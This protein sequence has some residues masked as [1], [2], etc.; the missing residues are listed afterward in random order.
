MITIN[1]RIV[2]LDISQDSLDAAYFEND[3][4][5]HRVFSNNRGGFRDLLK[6]CRKRGVELRFCMEATATYSW[7]VAEYLYERGFHVYVENPRLISSFGD[8]ENERNSTDKQSAG[9]IARYASSKLEKL[10]LWQ[11]LPAHLKKLRELTRLRQSLMDTKIEWTNRLKSK[12]LG[13][14]ASYAQKIIA[15]TSLAIKTI[16]RD[17]AKHVKETP[18]LKNDV[19]LLR[20]IKGI[21]LLTAVNILAEVPW[22][23]YFE[24]KRDLVAFAGMNPAIRKSGTSIN[25]KATLS[26]KGSSRIR[27][28]L[29]MPAVTALR[30]NKRIV[31]FAS[32][33]RAKGKH[34]MEIV[35]AA[36]RKLLCF[37]FGVL[38]SGE[39]FRENGDVPSTLKTT[40]RLKTK[41]QL[42]A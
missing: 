11:P 16:D 14:C 2:G 18:R 37:A 21:G 1:R 38:R 9:I 3:I 28:A 36:M 30:H 23:D 32:R 24:D 20:S 42:A 19:K 31:E 17:I 40:S 13:A 26:K 6:W 39:P 4:K 29:Y 34:P 25:F 15:E 10:R 5:V 35:A 22:L 33:L 12:A 7:D 27:K 8:S 41:R